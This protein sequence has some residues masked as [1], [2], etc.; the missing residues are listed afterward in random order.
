MTGYMG[1]SA[2]FLLID[3]ELIY[4]QM[5]GGEGV[6]IVLHIAYLR[7]ERSL[8]AVYLRRPYYFCIVRF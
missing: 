1:S 8:G 2:S 5:R 6:I 4:I 3:G 7:F